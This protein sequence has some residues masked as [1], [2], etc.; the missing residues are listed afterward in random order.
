MRKKMG[1]PKVSKKTPEDKIPE[2]KI[3]EDK[4]P[5]DNIPKSDIW[6]TLEDLMKRFKRSKSTINRWRREKKLICSEINSVVQV[7]KWDLEN[8]MWNHRIE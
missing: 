3:P 7:N 8:F 2:D 6:Y 4:I 1:H 5:G